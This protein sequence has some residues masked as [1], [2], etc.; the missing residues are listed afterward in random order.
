MIEVFKIL[1]NYYDTEATKNLLELSTVN[2]TRGHNLKLFSKHSR[3]NMRKYFF[4]NRVVSPWNSLPSHII[5]APSVIAFE[6]RLDKHWRNQEFVHD[7]DETFNSYEGAR[8]PP[9]ELDI[10]VA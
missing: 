9:P 3:T 10:E 2:H 6:R 7:F 1:N 4:S 5:H 8:P